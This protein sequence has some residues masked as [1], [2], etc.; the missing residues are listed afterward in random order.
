MGGLGFVLRNLGL[1]GVAGS[2]VCV[3][4]NRTCKAV[5]SGNGY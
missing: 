2:R 5:R 4:P 1:F 3:L